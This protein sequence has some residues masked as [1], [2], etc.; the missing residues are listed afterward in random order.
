MRTSLLFTL[1]P[2]IGLFLCS[3]LVT[4]ETSEEQAGVVPARD[5]RDRASI[6]D[7]SAIINREKESA[8][9][10]DPFAVNIRLALFQ[11]W[12]CEA[13]QVHKK[14]QLVK[15]AAQD[16][17]SA[18]ERA[19]TLNQRSSQAH[20]LVGE[21]LSRLIPQVFGGGMRYGKRAAEEMDKA[22]QLDPKNADA[23]VS[24]AVSYY[25]TP[26]A[27][28]GGTD[29]AFEFL[30]KAVE[31]DRN[32]DTPHIWRAIFH[33]EEKQIKEA[34]REILVAQEINPNRAFSKSIAD[35]IKVANDSNN[36]R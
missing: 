15:Q 18:A 3:K 34:F 24:R 26:R 7:L 1:A 9:A 5:A 20:Q 11:T 21:L 10:H 27:F 17:L 36:S 23:Y 32:A 31:L 13:A 30:Q 14:S 19:V 29:K 6:D 4:A 28:G 35:Q 12:M 8:S 25:Y 16:G 2:F 33:L 22:I